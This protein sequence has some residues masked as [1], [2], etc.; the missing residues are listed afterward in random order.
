LVR[1]PGEIGA[2]DCGDFT[3][4]TGADL[5]IRPLNRQLML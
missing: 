5:L 1:E 3:G 2:Y 4:F